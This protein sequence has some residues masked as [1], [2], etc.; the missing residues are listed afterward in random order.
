V[1]LVPS[2]DARVSLVASLR[3]A[4]HVFFS[5]PLLTDS[6]SGCASAVGEQGLKVDSVTVTRPTK[7][8]GQVTVKLVGHKVKLFKITG[9]AC[10]RRTAPSET[11]SGMTPRL[12]TVLG[13]NVFTTAQPVDGVTLIVPTPPG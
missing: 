2:T 13:K 9:R 10:V 3:K 4:G 11:C 5:L 7:R 1:G 12:A 8:N 6:G